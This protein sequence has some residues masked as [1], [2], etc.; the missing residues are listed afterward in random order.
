M[1]SLEEEAKSSFWVCCG[2]GFL[3]ACCCDFFFFIFFRKNFLHQQKTTHVQDRTCFDSGLG[4]NFCRTKSPHP[5]SPP[6]F[7]LVCGGKVWMEGEL[8]SLSQSDVLGIVTT[9]SAPPND[10]SYWLTFTLLLSLALQGSFGLL[11]FLTSSDLV[12]FGEI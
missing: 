6:S 12:L 5:L 2:G 1:P 8:L 3:D 7:S 10:S 11:S 9:T 4:L